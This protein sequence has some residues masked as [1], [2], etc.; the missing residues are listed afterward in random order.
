MCCAECKV[1]AGGIEMATRN[2]KV[3]PVIRKAGRQLAWLV[4]H[5]RWKN[6][7]VKF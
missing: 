3:T 5:L 4:L 1:H 2:I 6:D 7:V